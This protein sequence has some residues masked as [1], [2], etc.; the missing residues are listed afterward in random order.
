MHLEM[1][2]REEPVNAKV[3]I[4]CTLIVYID[5]L[6]PI[7]EVHADELAIES[8]IATSLVAR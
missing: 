7:N 1:E 3:T 6:I 2:K 8:A 5:Y 4:D